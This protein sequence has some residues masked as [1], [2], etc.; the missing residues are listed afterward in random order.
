MSQPSKEVEQ[1]L[2]LLKSWR[3]TVIYVANKL[4]ELRDQMTSVE[5]GAIAGE[6]NAMIVIAREV[7]VNIDA[8]MKRVVSKN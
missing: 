1:W 5:Q 4:E 2:Y 6:V 3:S 8:A 7:C